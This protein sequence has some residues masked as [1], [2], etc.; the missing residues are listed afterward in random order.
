MAAVTF[1]IAL[2]S[3]YLI[4][5]TVYVSDAITN[6]LGREIRSHL[7]RISAGQYGRRASSWA[8]LLG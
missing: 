8:R 6:H 7:V 5:D 1:A 4:S 2:W 3:T